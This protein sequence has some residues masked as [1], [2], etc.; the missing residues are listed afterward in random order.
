MRK[1]HCYD[2]HGDTVESVLEEFNERRGEFKVPD[3]D[4]VSIST[5]TAATPLNIHTG[6]GTVKSTVIVTIFYWSDE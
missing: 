1:L 3:A 6:K 5:R 4:I 2:I